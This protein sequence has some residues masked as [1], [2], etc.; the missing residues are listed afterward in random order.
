MNIV[1]TKKKGGQKMQHK[2]LI[3]S[4]VLLLGLGSLGLRAQTSVN[5][6]GGNAVG[7]GGSVSYSVGQL[8]YTTNKG[9]SGSVEQGVHHTYEITAVSV[10]ER[11]LN[12]KLHLIP[13]AV[14]DHLILQI[15]D[16][17]YQKLSYLLFDSQ[18]IELSKGQ[19]VEKQ[20]LINMRSLPE[21]TYFLTV[22]NQENK[23]SLTFKITKNQ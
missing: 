18:G 10:R 5:T 3:F 23:K 6:T 19:I 9:S 16:Y 20:T 1:I 4:A 15:N 17:N 12:N 7:S 14:T 21:A 8:F 22:V 11:K 2:R 13:N